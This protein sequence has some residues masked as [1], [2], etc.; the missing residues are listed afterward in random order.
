MAICWW[1]R[2]IYHKYVYVITLSWYVTQSRKP[3]QITHQT[4]KSHVHALGCMAGYVPCIEQVHMLSH[5]LS[6]G[7]WK[8]VKKNGYIKNVWWV[9]GHSKWE[10]SF[11]SSVSV[12]LK[13]PHCMSLA[14]ATFLQKSRDVMQ[15][16]T[17]FSGTNS[18]VNN[19]WGTCRQ[20]LSLVGNT[21]LE[22][23]IKA[24]LSLKRAALNTIL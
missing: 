20:R 6:P 22:I 12:I 5:P 2:C 24:K 9:L 14:T 8:L 7:Y 10:S 11:P 17:P 1:C 21:K 4:N 15:F 18:G 13:H 19:G 23:S 16:K 3:F